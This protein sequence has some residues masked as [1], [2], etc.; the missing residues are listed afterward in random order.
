M[1]QIYV[2]PNSMCEGLQLTNFEPLGPTWTGSP[3]VWFGPT[4]DRK[5]CRVSGFSSLAGG[6]EVPCQVTKVRAPGGQVGYL[7]HGADWGVVI[8][9]WRKG[10][11]VGR[12]I[13]WV[14]DGEDLPEDV[15]RY[16]DRTLAH[17]EE[18][19]QPLTSA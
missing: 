18:D 7:I 5:L 9:G 11:I 13:V 8:K 19:T 16:C 1:L 15:R 10:Q 2:K 6:R 17:S 4:E 3:R 12:P 14:A